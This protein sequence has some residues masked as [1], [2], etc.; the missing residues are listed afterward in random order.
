[1]EINYIHLRPTTEHPECIIENAIRLLLYAHDI[2]L[3]QTLKVNIRLLP[4]QNTNVVKVS[5]DC[6]DRQRES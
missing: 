4:L 6:T 2:A 3:D 1:M 5:K